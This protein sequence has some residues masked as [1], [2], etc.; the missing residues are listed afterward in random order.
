MHQTEKITTCLTGAPLA[1][2]RVP[3]NMPIKIPVYAPTQRMADYRVGLARN[4]FNTVKCFIGYRREKNSAASVGW[5]LG[6][7]PVN[8]LQPLIKSDILGLLVK[9]VLKSVPR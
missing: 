4:R 5:A 7:M 3:N 1:K 2:L 9:P 8:M 6:P